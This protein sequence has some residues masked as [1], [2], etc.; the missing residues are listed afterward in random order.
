MGTALAVV[1]LYI[2]GEEFLDQSLVLGQRLG[3]S[4]KSIGT[5]LVSF[6]AV[7]D[8]FAVVLASSFRGFGGISFGTVQGSNVVTMIVFL[9]L[10]LAVQKRGYS[11]FRF[12]AVLM[13]LMT[14]LALVFSYL[15]GI[16][17][18]FLGLPMIILYGLYAYFNRSPTDSPLVKEAEEHVGKRSY[19]SL[20]L[21]LVL[22]VLSSDAIVKY[23]NGIAT[24]SGISPFVS[25]FVITGI[26]GSLPEI[27]MFA[28]SAARKEEESMLGIVTGTTIYKGSLILG[29]ALIF[30]TISMRGGQWS[31]FVMMALV[32]VFLFLTVLRK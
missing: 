27:V 28:I 15:F 18:W 9:P 14:V 5:Y 30:G 17:P 16:D 19:V 26:A 1:A 3:M 8:E 11:K 22:L 21:S 32:L 31:I 24:A 13:L 29:I 12:D 2:S 7:V 6:G 20:I 4:K 25:G 23:T 10:L